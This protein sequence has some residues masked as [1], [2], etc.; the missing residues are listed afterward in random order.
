MR[1]SWD[2]YFLAIAHL[3]SIRSHDEQ[4][5]VG[6]VIVNGDNHIVGVGYNGFPSGIED[7]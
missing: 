5:Q 1:P 2:Q 7:S 6:C 3:V 4:T